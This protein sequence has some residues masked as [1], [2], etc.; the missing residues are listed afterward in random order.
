MT[1]YRLVYSSPSSGGVTSTVSSNSSSVALHASTSASAT[2]V[3]GVPSVSEWQMVRSSRAGRAAHN[4]SRSI[5]AVM[6]RSSSMS[7]SHTSRYRTW[8]CDGSQRCHGVGIEPLNVSSQ[9]PRARQ[10]QAPRIE[11]EAIKT[12]NGNLSTRNNKPTGDRIAWMGGLNSFFVL[13]VTKLLAKY[14]SRRTV[15]ARCSDV[16]GNVI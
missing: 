4:T 15:L 9:D 2:P 11:D 6:S 14:L 10:G 7:L 16:P 3:A 8:H 1:S 13:L 5:S 12:G